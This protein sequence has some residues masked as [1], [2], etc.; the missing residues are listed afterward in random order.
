MRREV[1]RERDWQGL[2]AVQELEAALRE[3]ERPESPVGT[4]VARTAEILS[5]LGATDEEAARLAQ[6][7]LQYAQLVHAHEDGLSGRQEALARRLYSMHRFLDGVSGADHFGA[8]Q[9][10]RDDIQ[11]GLGIG[12]KDGSML[13]FLSRLMEPGEHGEHGAHDDHDNA[14]TRSFDDEAEG[15]IDAVHSG[16]AGLEQ[17]FSTQMI[18]RYD[19]V[20]SRKVLGLS[21]GMAARFGRLAAEPE[22]RSAQVD[23]V[24]GK[25]FST[26]RRQA[27]DTGIRSLR[28][29]AMLFDLDAPVSDRA[30]HEVSPGDGESQ[31]CLSLADAVISRMHGHLAVHWQNRMESVFRGSGC[32]DGRIYDERRFLGDGAGQKNW[33]QSDLAFEDETVRAEPEPGHTYIVC[34][35]DRLSTLTARAY[36]GQGDYRNVLRQN[37]HILQPDRLEPGTRIYFPDAHAAPE[38]HEEAVAPAYD[39]DGHCILYAGRVITS[40][41]P[42]T[43]QQ[44]D[45]F[46]GAIARLTDADLM[47]TGAIRL[48]VGRAVVCRRVTLL[49][50]VDENEPGARAMFPKEGDPVAAW[51]SMLA[52]EIR[53]DVILRGGVFLPLASLPQQ[54][55]RRSWFA[56]ALHRVIHDERAM[57]LRFLVHARSGAVDVVDAQHQV[58]L[59]LEPEDFEAIRRQPHRRLEDYIAPPVVQADALTQLW[60]SAISAGALEIAVPP[61]AHANQYAI[62]Q[63]EECAQILAPMGTPVFPV[64]RGVVVDCGRYP[65]IGFG[66]LIRHPGGLYCRYTGLASVGVRPDQEVHADTMIAR[67]G[68][69]EQCDQPMLLLEMRQCDDDIDDWQGFHGTP[70]GYFE[71]IGNLWPTRTAFECILGE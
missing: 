4:H 48:P 23:L 44:R 10:S 17:Y 68:C 11:Y 58:V 18:L 61:V 71:V 26:A 25:R 9:G 43:A 15:L 56:T 63:P 2:A 47:G 52:A 66:I 16:Q 38:T 64:M 59:R 51:V 33:E 1:E 57:P 42:M 21:D 12:L 5:R 65:G 34:A 29:F 45:G 20:M 31:K 67:T 35:G 24:A 62:S 60:L 19:P 7:A 6:F 46:I 14:I 70:L 69:A 37:P 32:I 54:P 27:H 41:A 28:G 53:G 36:H 50:T 3:A 40:I 13:R 8:I 22:A 49:M 55:H 39:A 30:I